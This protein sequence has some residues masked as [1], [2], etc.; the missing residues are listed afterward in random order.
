MS[1]LVNFPFNESAHENFIFTESVMHNFLK[2]VCWC[3]FYLSIVWICEM[4]HEMIHMLTAL[5]EERIEHFPSLVV[6][7]LTVVVCEKLYMSGLTYESI[8]KLG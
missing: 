1:L 5:K 3:M 7:E 6:L 4:S 8:F 2:T